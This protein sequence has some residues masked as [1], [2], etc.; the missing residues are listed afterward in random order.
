MLFKTKDPSENSFPTFSPVSKYVFFPSLPPSSSFTNH[1]FYR[2]V[3]ALSTRHGYSISV[4]DARMGLLGQTSI[5][6][7]YCIRTNRGRSTWFT[8]FRET[9][10]LLDFPPSFTSIVT[11]VVLCISPLYFSL[12]DFTLFFIVPFFFQF[13]FIH[14]KSSGNDVESLAF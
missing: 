1:P 7:S 11:F 3:T 12:R 13:A 2:L 8:L 5:R 14:Q 4:R 10:F 9:S 6:T